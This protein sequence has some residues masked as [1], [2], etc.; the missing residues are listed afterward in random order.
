MQRF[1]NSQKLTHTHTHTHTDTQIYL[2]KLVTFV[3]SDTRAPFSIATT[4]RC[5]GG[6]YSFLWMA[7]LYPL[8]LPYNAEC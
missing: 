8:S 1:T 3:E 5:R 7:P 4:P 2:Y 6:R